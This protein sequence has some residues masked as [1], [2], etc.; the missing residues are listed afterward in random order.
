M[1]RLYLGGGIPWSGTEKYARRLRDASFLHDMTFPLETHSIC[2]ST[3]VVPVHGITRSVTKTS[4]SLLGAIKPCEPG[5]TYYTS[6][7]EVKFSKPPPV[8]PRAV[9][10]NRGSSALSSGCRM[11]KGMVFC[12]SPLL[13]TSLRHLYFWVSPVDRLGLIPHLWRQIA[14]CCSVWRFWLCV[15]SS[16]ARDYWLPC[17]ASKTRSLERH[18]RFSGRWITPREVHPVCLLASHES[19]IK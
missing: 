6:D 19:A 13:R 12:F 2:P 11:S 8:R 9:N 18:S 17:E 10:Q 5:C 1:M 7:Q 15:E 3:V 16:R 4:W 14:H